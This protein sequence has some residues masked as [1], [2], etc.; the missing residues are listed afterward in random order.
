MLKKNSS[1]DPF[2]KSP[3]SACLHDRA[4]ELSHSVSSITVKIYEILLLSKV[5]FLL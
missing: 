5:I 1:Y 4:D 3:S 2:A